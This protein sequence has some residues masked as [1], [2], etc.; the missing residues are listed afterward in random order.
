MNNITLE[1][2]LNSTR[3]LVGR[4]TVFHLHM[5]NGND[6]TTQ[7]VGSKLSDWFL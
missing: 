1:N 2:N 4:L 6:V 7:K 3:A 5:K